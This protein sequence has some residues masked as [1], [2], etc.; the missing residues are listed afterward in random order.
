MIR[1]FLLS[2]VA[3]GSL[4]LGQIATA[5]TTV[6]TDP[7]G[8]TTLSVAAKPANSR[9]FTLLSLNMTRPVVFQGL[10]P[11]GGV[12]T[13]N[14]QTT[15]TFPAN[16]FT[17]N[18]FN[19][20][21]NG[22]YIEIANGP[23]AGRLSDIV[24]TSSSAG[25]SSITLAD[26]ISAAVTAG[27][28]TIKIRPNWTFATA[29]G[30]N[31][32]AGFKGAGSSS[33]A[34]V[35]QLVDPATNVA[36]TYFYSTTNNRWQEGFRDA[37]N[38]EIPIDS[39][40]KIERKETSPVSFTLAGA[41]KLGPTGL[42][43]QGGAVPQ[44]STIVPNPYPMASVTLANSNLF[45]GDPATGVRGAGSASQADTVN[46][47]NPATGLYTTYFYST[48]NNRWQNGFQDASN[49]TLPEGA[50]VIINRKST[51]TT[52]NPSFIWYAPQPA[53]NL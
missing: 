26:D 48:T 21:G 51:S 10:V 38:D 3:I 43:V 37:T 16:T 12:S 41:V 45:T 27:T 36:R 18:Q 32:S 13:S 20:A 33:Q 24:A 8:F 31:N 52:Q 14:G 49:V 40:L 50:A 25:S 11:S 22:H 5:Q 39:G 9:G 30:A 15:L 19:G 42:F 47:L 46:V 1:S 7:V 6:A 4:S 44:N 23:A 17:A 53:M 2:A 34:D 28:S 35:I 29:F